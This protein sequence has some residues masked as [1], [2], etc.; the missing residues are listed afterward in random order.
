MVII[1][2][3]CGLRPRICIGTV[4][5]VQGSTF[6]WVVFGSEISTIP[7]WLLSR[8]TR[9]AKYHNYQLE[10]LTLHAGWQNNVPGGD[11]RGGEEFRRV[12]RCAREGGFPGFMAIGGGA[13]DFRGG[14]GDE[15]GTRFSEVH[16]DWQGVG[17]LS[18]FYP[19]GPRL[20]MMTADTA[21]SASAGDD[22]DH[23]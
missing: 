20:W 4:F 5:Y 22:G 23:G 2:A 15:G 11:A 13:W 8:E 3:A 10:K 14:Y 19:R 21:D 12:R 7:L 17:I 16:G 18:R 6:E 9:A 1:F